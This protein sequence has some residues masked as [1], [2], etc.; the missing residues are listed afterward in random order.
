MTGL[1]GTLTSGRKLIAIVHAPALRSCGSALASVEAERS[2]TIAAR[3]GLQRFGVELADRVPEADVGG[4]TAARRLADRGLVDLEHALDMAEA[5][6][7]AQP[8]Q[9]G[10]W[11]AAS[12]SRP[13]LVGLRHG[14]GDV[15]A[16]APRARRSTCPSADAGDRHQALERTA[17]VTSLRL[18]S[19]RAR[20]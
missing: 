4:W 8:C 9:T 5:V 6:Q 19:W 3:L 18:C 16:A 2:R 7:A 12:A 11:P 1:A 14:G 15:G 10:S 13:A 20:R 17:A